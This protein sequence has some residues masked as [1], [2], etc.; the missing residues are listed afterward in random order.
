MLQGRIIKSLAGFY[1]VE[2]QNV[3]YTCKARGKFRK[4]NMKPVVGDLCDFEIDDN[5]E[6]YIKKIAK[7]KNYL[8]IPPI[9]NIDQALLV[10]S[11]T[12]PD[13]D[14]LLL[15]RFLANVEHKDVKPI[16]VITKIDLDSSRMEKI[17]QDYHDYQIIFV[18]SK[19]HIGI[20][21]VKANLKDKVTVVTGQS[22][23]GK[24]SLLTALDIQLHI[25]TNEISD[26]LGRGKHTTRHVELIKMHGGYV[27]DTPGFS[28]LELEMEP[29][30]LAVSYHD[31]RRLSESCK[32]RG[33]LHD[34]EP[35][36]AVK[37]AVEDG[38]IAKDRYL[39]YLSFL[40]EVKEIK[41]K[42]YG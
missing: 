24:S 6:G 8:T 35:Y 19:E 16:I 33:C 2:S 3:L 10:F 14:S 42:R 34:S 31:F 40:K 37:Q 12:H 22:G 29:R 20:D 32:F 11:I 28:S 17:K 36:C 13:F 26:A 27:A 5:Q 9:S 18:S 25:E 38:E 7:R 30:E 15:D 39:H 23:V 4:E 21:E 1:Y 41:E